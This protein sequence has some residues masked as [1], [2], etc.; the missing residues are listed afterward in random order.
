MSNESWRPKLH[1]AAYNG[2]VSDPNG[3]NQ[4]RGTYHFF[5]QY[6][7]TYPPHADSPHG[8]GHC[9]I[10]INTKRGKIGKPQVD[11]RAQ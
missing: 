3:L 6:A 2:S 11:F 9:V 1:L 5:S 4:F 8:W 7:P 10:M